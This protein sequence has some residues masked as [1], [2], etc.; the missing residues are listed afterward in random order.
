MAELLDHETLIAVAA[1]GKALAASRDVALVNK[2]TDLLHL[3]VCEFALKSGF[4][5][6]AAEGREETSQRT[7]SLSHCFRRSLHLQYG[8]PLVVHNADLRVN[9]ECG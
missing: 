9:R 2:D 4:T 6:L 3:F 7:P 8:L 1:A 5:L